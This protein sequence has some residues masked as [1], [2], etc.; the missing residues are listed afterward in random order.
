MSNIKLKKGLGRG[1]SSL[2]GDIKEE[3]KKKEN[4]SDQIKVLIA[5][6]NNL[7]KILR[8]FIVISQMK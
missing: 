2:F 5:K 6:K 1:L 4:S 7:Q 8:I 3:I